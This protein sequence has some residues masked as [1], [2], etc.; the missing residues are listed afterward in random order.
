MADEKLVL[1][2]VV[3][4]D[5]KTGIQEVEQLGTAAKADVKIFNDLKKGILDGVNEPLKQATDSQ[6]K[7][8]DEVKKFGKE[9]DTATK[10]LKT[11]IKEAKQEAL[12]LADAFGEN[13]AQ[14]RNAQKAVAGLVDKQGDLNDRI[15]AFNPDAKF[16]ALTQV[17]GGA[18]GGFQA[19]TGALQVFGS[20]NEEVNAIVDKFQGLINVAGGLSQLGQLKDAFGNLKSVLGITTVA[21]EAL[22]VATVET[23]VAEEAS[24]VALEGVAV[25][26]TEVAVG[27][28]AAITALEGVAVAETEVATAGAAL[29]L[30]LLPIIAVIAAAAAV[31]YLFTRGMNDQADAI[32]KSNKA[33]AENIKNIDALAKS[34]EQYIGGSEQ[35]IALLAAQ[36]ASEKT[37]TEARIRGLKSDQEFLKI[38]REKAISATVYAEL[39][40]KIFDISNQQQI[41]ETK[42]IKINADL[43][44]KAKQDAIEKEKESLKDLQKIQLRGTE[45]VYLTPAQEQQ[46]RLFELLITNNK[47]KLGQLNAEA[48]K[49]PD[50]L[51]APPPPPYQGSTQEFLDNEKKKQAGINETKQ[52]VV[53]GADV[54]GQILSTALSVQSAANK[55]FYDD[56]IQQEDNKL[57]RKE[58]TQKEYDQRVRK[59]RNK[60]AE[61]EKRLALYQAGIDIAIAILKANALGP[62]Q[63]I[64]AI[65]FAVA[66]GAAQIGAIQSR[67]LPKFFKGSKFVNGGAGGVDDIPAFVNRGEAIIP[68]ATNKA[69]FPT[70]S[71]IYDGKI[72]PSTINAFVERE[73]KGIP[74]AAVTRMDNYDLIR[75]VKG[76]SQVSI[77]N[78]NSLA[79]AI[80][81]E[82]ALHTN[83]R[84]Q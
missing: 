79:K 43:R 76:N 60:A 81:R 11:Q 3:E 72:K 47:Q 63:N 35:V 22:T 40:K 34:Y 31:G 83:L 48:S 15:K 66:L 71:A 68:T 80:A 33:S 54:A 10:T 23:T 16:Q 39:N 49:L 82:L 59:I 52:I 9:G 6:K 57:K 53:Q 27:G 29:Y 51:P 41:E 77:R 38:G 78:E 1:K 30:E 62:P 5:L 56:Q 58:I 25:A 37:L 69:Y 8:T 21:Q 70:I 75:A 2:I 7:L 12:K 17:L 18:F 61:E 64:A 65:A 13:S 19:L 55:A 74:H 73:R 44:L 42:L 45:N 28:A 20:K 67:P 4:S 84:M 32:D 46:L 36:G 50:A 24:I 14:A 26:E